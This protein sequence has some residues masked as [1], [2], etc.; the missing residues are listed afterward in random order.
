[1][2]IPTILSKRPVIWALAICLVIV[3]GG[4]VFSRRSASETPAQPSTST[5]TAPA[6]VAIAKAIDL[7]TVAS[8]EHL[9]GIIVPK[10]ETSVVSATS[11]T[12]AAAPFEVGDTVSL[13]SILFR[14]DTPFGSAVSKDGL[15]SET[16]RQA[17]IAVSLAKKSYKDAARLTEKKSTKSVANTLARDLAKLR[18]ESA[19]IAL[20]NARNN[21]LVRATFSG[22]ISQKNVG[23]GS[24]VS[25]GIELA[26]IASDDTS[27]V[28]FSVSVGTREKLA[29]GDTVTLQ[30]GDATS[31]EARITSVGAIADSGTGK[32]PVEAKLSSNTFRAG[33]IATVIL[34][35]KSTVTETA[36]F[37]LPLSAITTG[38]DG[39]F[40]FVEES[41]TAKKV[42]VDSVTVSGEIGIVSADISDDAN[43][44]VET[45]RTLEDGSMVNIN[46]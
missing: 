3:V 18:L 41:G 8:E 13:G 25:P 22:V 6:Q 30:A 37:S 17:E 14:I 35:S 16:I 36:V 43:I 32:F 40:F 45:G 28:K 20:D 15:S 19:E 10:Y 39:S 12:I 11:G 31:S 21:T 27:L 34:T 2:A 33:T 44:I 38:Q 46:A 5:T 26:S 42:N 29:L 4:V 7:K 24:A 23:I 1:M 9:P